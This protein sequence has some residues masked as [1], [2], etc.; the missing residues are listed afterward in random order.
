MNRVGTL[1]IVIGEKDCWG[2]GYGTE[3]QKFLIMHV[4]DRLP[5]IKT[6]EMYMV[7]YPSK[8]AC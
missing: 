2:K 4:F 6:I 8:R 5:A 1:G 7:A 3:I